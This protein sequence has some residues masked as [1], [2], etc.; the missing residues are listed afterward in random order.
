MTFEIKSI[1]Y[2]A[3]ILQ[4][5]SQLHTCVFVPSKMCFTHLFGNKR[6]QAHIQKQNNIHD[7]GR[8]QQSP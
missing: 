2:F 5:K 8:M 1:K 3:Y 6:L 4:A 7:A